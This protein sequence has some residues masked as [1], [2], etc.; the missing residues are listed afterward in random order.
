MKTLA[1]IF[2][3]AA[4]SVSGAFAETVPHNDEAAKKAT[5]SIPF[6]PYQ[7]RP[8]GTATPSSGTTATVASPKLPLQPDQKRPTG[9][10]NKPD[11]AEAS[12]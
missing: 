1:I 7:K 4:L 9:S 8:L 3:G 11:Q 5:P 10:A 2:L 12:R 6:R